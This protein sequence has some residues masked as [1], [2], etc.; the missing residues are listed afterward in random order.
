LILGQSNSAG[1]QLAD[2]ARAWPNLVLTSLPSLLGTPVTGVFRSFYAR[3]P[4]AA[5]YL[6]RELARHRPD[7]VI[8]TLTPFAFLVPMV[9]PGV[10][11]RY[12]NRL[13]DIYER[14][15][16]RFNRATRDGGQASTAANRLAR[17]LAH[18][19]LGAA[20]VASF[21]EVIEGTSVALRRLAREEDL[22]VIAFQGLIRT[23]GGRGR[24]AESRRDLLGHYLTATRS[25]AQ[26][27]YVPYLDLPSGTLQT[28]DRF[29]LPDS[30]H[31]RPEVHAAMAAVILAAFS[32]GTLD[33]IGLGA[34]A[35][36]PR[37]D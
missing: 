4:R 25:L 21:E 13:G 37:V 34:G 35:D 26:Q 14:L 17:R 5:E 7:I 12:G 9:G 24:R 18:L 19:L 8:L 32:Q 22:Q 33:R 36:R 15:E 20:P 27:L 6:E 2:P 3:A 28:S 16:A 30:T 11:K 10:R 31:V 23:P 1:A 29:F